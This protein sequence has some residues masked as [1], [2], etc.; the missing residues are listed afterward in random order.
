MIVQAYY[1]TTNMSDSLCRFANKINNN[2]NKE[3]I[4]EELLTA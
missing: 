1:Q 2:T 4:S 3:I